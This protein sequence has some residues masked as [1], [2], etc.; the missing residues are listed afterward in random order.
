MSQDKPLF[1]VTGA[2][3]SIGKVIAANLAT[4][5]KAVVLACRN[6]D[7]AQAL[8]KDLANATKNNDITALKLDLSSFAG[9]RAF[10]KSLRQLNRPVAALVNNA[11]TMERHSKVSDDGFELTIQV[12]Y[13]STALLS[14]LVAPLIEPKGMV[15]FTTS[16]MR[17]FCSIPAGFP[18]VENFSQL[19]TYSRS[20]L[21]LTLFS[22]YLS[23]TLKNSE[24]RVNCVD[25]GIV[26]TNM[27]TM[28]RWFDSIA[29]IAFRPFVKKPIEGAACTMKALESDTTGMV[30][31]SKDTHRASEWLKDKDVFVRLLNDT[32]RRIKPEMK[33]D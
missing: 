3:G 24:V 6:I 25:P 22:I 23:T 10:V 7:R 9:V 5:G 18:S 32:L 8:A 33:M 27:L 28:N 30:F 14:L 20:K 2:T 17:N 29:N 15:L 31:S 16:V 11:G 1:I 4:Q 21:A 26:D 12:N 19:M 13:L